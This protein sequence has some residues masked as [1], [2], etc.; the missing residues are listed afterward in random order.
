MDGAAW[1]Q[2]RGDLL[3]TRW[4]AAAFLNNLETACTTISRTEWVIRWLNIGDAHCVLGDTNIEK[5]YF[6]EVAEDWLCALTAFEVARRL[7]CEDASKIESVSAKINTV[8]QKLGKLGPKVER[9]Q[10]KCCD[11]FEISAHYLPARDRSSAAPAIICISTEGETATTLLGRLL[12]VVMHRGM[13]ILV[14]AHDDLSDTGRSLSDMFLS[15]CVDYLSTRSD[16]DA[17]RIG[18]YGDGLSAA[19]ATDL[20]AFDSRVAAAVCDGGLWNWARTLASVDWLTGTADVQDER[21]ISARRLRL[22]RQLRCPV[23]VVAGGRGIISAAEAM[24]LLGDGAAAP[25]DLQL[26]IPRMLTIDGE[27]FENFVTAD[28]RIFGWLEHKLVRNT[29]SNQC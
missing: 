24:K 14:V 21:V 3:S 15:C 16:V 11:Q 29:L 27:E 7:A 25:I 23:L 17:A 6:D 4:G 20:A 8:I 28:D 19:L 13:S 26:A 1:P 5:G 12:P 22:L 10:I 18:V 2:V 9:V